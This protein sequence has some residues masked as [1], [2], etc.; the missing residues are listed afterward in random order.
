MN[1]QAIKELALANGFKL[2]E[3][4]DGSID[5]NP[6]VYEFALAL[7][8]DAGRK[9]Y[10]QALFDQFAGNYQAL[11][12]LKFKPDQYADRLRRGGE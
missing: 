5:L 8:V 1:K 6:Y 10:A 11:D 12:E 9:G 3:Q 4:P 7:I 2:K